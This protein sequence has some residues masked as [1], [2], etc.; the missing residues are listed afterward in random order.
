LINKMNQELDRSSRLTIVT[1][2][3]LQVSFFRPAS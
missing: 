1:T 3:A 2:I